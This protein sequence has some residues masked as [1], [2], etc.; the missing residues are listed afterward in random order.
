MEEEKI[1][2]TVNSV[3]FRNDMNGYTVL[4]IE[5]GD[6]DIFTAVGTLPALVPGENVVFSGSWTV[7]PSYGRQFKIESF[8]RMQ[9][10]TADDQYNYLASGAIRGIREATARKIIEKFGDK[11]FDVISEDPRRLATV[12]GIS[13]ER[14]KEISEEFNKTFSEREI[15]IAFEKYGLNASESI[16][17]FQALGDNAVAEVERNPY[18]I[19]DEIIGMSFEKAESVAERLNVKPDSDYRISAGIKYVLQYNLFNGHT[20][21]PRKKLIP[22]C[23]DL[24][25]ID[26]DEIE[27]SIDRLIENKSIVSENVKGKPFVFLNEIYKAEK[28]CAKQLVF[29]KNYAVSGNKATND[30]IQQIE[31]ISGICYNDVQKRAIRTA[32]EKGLLVLTG[33]P[34]TGKT[35]TIRA[36]ISLF[37][38]DGIE[39]VLCAPTGRAAKRMSELTGYEAKTIHRLLEVEWDKHD[40]PVFTRNAQNP[41]DAD[42]LIVDELSMVDVR[43]FEALLEALPIGCRLVMVGDSDQ[44]PPVGAGNVLQDIINSGIIPVVELNEVFRQAMQSSIVVNAHKIVHGE[45]PDLSIH[46]SDF[47]FLSRKSPFTAAETIADLCC[48]RLPEAYK[49][50]SFNDIQIIAPSRIGE[51]G[52]VNLNKRLQ[53]VLNP[54]SSGKKEFSSAG[55]V[56]REGDKIMQTKN[57]Y[58]IEWESSADGTKGMGIFNGDIGIIKKIDIL[59]AY[60]NISFD[61]KDVLYPLENAVQLEHAYAITVHKSQG[62]EFKA[63]IIPVCGIPEKLAYRNLLYTAVTRAREILILVGDENCV[64]SMISNNSKAKR[65]SALQDFLIMEK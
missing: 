49:Y 13:F 18:I 32:V 36:I 17:L 5:T 31:I 15:I 1:T 23:E 29:R 37:N 51:S 62:S 39:T 3:T 40:K 2:G 61:D 41:I 19:C 6:G 38:N 55:R 25:D 43:L 26:K 24:L 35:T 12:K 20:C 60:M 27:K 30:R 16:K 56:F 8:E 14:A 53:S 33:G 47:F 7:H 58:D 42:A 64:F 44:L 65:Y 48:R 57:N 28:S 46:N 34:G 45:M 52:T 9:I 59:N 63:V 21:I 11:S 22:P 10:K 50:S 54:Q 4:D